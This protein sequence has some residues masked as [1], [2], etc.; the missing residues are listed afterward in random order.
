MHDNDIHRII[1]AVIRM[2]RINVPPI[3]EGHRDGVDD[4]AVDIMA[5]IEA[6]GFTFAKRT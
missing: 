4:L 1:S 5:A 3:Q 2:A 6:E